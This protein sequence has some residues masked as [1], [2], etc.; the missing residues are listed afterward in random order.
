M[1]KTQ[2]WGQL[3]GA[4]DYGKQVTQTFT[5]AKTF[6]FQ[7]RCIPKEAGVLPHITNARHASVAASTDFNAAD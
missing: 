5:I 2:F 4:F 1:P 7:M 3:P 6:S